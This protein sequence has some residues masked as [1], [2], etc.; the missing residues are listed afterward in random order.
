ME[1]FCRYHKDMHTQTEIDNYD[2]TAC[3][4]HKCCVMPVQCLFFQSCPMHPINPISGKRA[5]MNLA[6]SVN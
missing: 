2:H 5:N 3:K 4:K 6:W 1:F